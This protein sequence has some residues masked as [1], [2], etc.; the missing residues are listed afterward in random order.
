VLMAYCDMKSVAT[1]KRLAGAPG[2]FGFA[3]LAGD[4]ALVKEVHREAQ[5][6]LG[7]AEAAPL[8]A[9]F[10]DW[11]VD[12]YG[13]GWHYFALGHDGVVDSQAMLKPMAHRDLFVC[14]EAYSLAQGWVEGAL[15]RAETLLQQHF[16][17]KPPVWL[18]A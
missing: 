12:P 15:E 7:K 2:P 13:G 9:C 6:V 14:G 17:L 10:Q 5:L 8:A 18:K 11:S 16:A 3:T 4:S 1:W